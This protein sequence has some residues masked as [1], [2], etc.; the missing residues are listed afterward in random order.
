MEKTWQ[1]YINGHWVSAQSGRAFAVVNPATQDVIAPGARWR[2]RRGACGGGGGGG[3]CWT[4][5]GCPGEREASSS[6]MR[7]S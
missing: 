1:L 5:R 7:I 4:G 6:L 2:A 3:R